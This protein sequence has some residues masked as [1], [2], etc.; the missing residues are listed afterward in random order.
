MFES[1]KAAIGEG[2]M[3][4]EELAKKDEVHHSFPTPLQLRMAI[5]T[6][7]DLSTSLKLAEI[8]RNT[9]SGTARVPVAL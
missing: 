5:F 7:L 2:A 9:F 6:L 1:L 4:V 8:Y 3:T